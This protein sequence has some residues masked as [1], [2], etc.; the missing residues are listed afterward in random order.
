M[1]FIQIFSP[2]SVGLFF[3]KKFILIL[4]ES[5]KL[6]LHHL[7]NPPSKAKTKSGSYQ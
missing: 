3:A 6:H 2:A 1:H 7:L 4:C 5:L